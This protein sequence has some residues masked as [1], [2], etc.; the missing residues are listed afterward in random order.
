MINLSKIKKGDQVVTIKGDILTFY[1]YY[2]D[3]YHYPYAFKTKDDLIRT[4]NVN[5]C[6]LESDFKGPQNI[7]SFVETRNP[8]KK[9]SN[10][11]KVKIQIS[12]TTNDKDHPTLYS[13]DIIF[14]HDQTLWT[15][16]S[17][18]F[19]YKRRSDASRGAKRFCSKFGLEIANPQKNP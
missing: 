14:L 4:Y 12:S 18:M 8:S 16:V 19:S 13:F 6:Y 1:K 17:S 9:I 3:W 5:G 15:H 11:G 2:G 10:K 7:E